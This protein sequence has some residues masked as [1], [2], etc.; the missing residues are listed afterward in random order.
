MN[1]RSVGSTASTEVLVL[2][3]TY[4]HPSESSREIVCTAGLTP[5]GRWV[6]LYPVDF[7]Y[8]SRDKQYSKYQWIR[9]DTRPA[10][11]H[12]DGRKE[13]RIPALDTLRLG[14]RLPA[15]SWAERRAVVEL[16]GTHTMGELHRLYEVDRTSLGVVEPSE[17]V[18]LEYSPCS[19]EWKPKWQRLFGQ[20]SLFGETQKPLRKVPYAFRYVFRCAD[21]SSVY[22]RLITDWE[23]GALF[24]KEVKR[25]GSEGDAARSVKHKFLEELCGEARNTRF[26]MGTHW[27]YNTWLVLGVF[28]PPRTP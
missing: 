1:P 17:V 8:R 7:R 16:A 10:D 22:R 15:G 13:S 25:L 5:E 9:V 19:R 20:I 23:L 21:C 18:D 11:P 2:V 14:P 3:K 12:R 24:W 26:F 4:P 27:P 28:W 6:R